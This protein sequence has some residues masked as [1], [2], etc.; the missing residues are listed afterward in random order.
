MGGRTTELQE[1]L[2]LLDAVLSNDE[3][4]RFKLVRQWDAGKPSVLFVML[5]PS[6]ADAKENDATINKCIRYARSWGFGGVTVGNLFSIRTKDPLEM[7]RATTSD[8]LDLLENDLHLKAMRSECDLCIVAW[9]NHGERYPGRLQE[10]LE[11]LGECHALRITKR[12][13]PAHPLYLASTRT[14]FAVQREPNGLL[15]RR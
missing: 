11:L 7:H 2:V 4:H 13:Q 8:R 1:G 9:G 5:N 6:T 10:V 15:R 12:H 14:P 3:L